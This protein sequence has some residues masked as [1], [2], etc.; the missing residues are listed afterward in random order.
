MS[1]AVRGSKSLRRKSVGF[2][3]RMDNL[4]AR[5]LLATIAVTSLADSGAGS[6]RQAIE[7]AAAN[8]TIDLTGLTGTIT[9]AS[10]IEL[11]KPLTLNG[12]GASR[13]SISGGDAVRIFDQS[14]ASN[15]TVV[16]R[17]MTLRDGRDVQYGGA[18]HV[19]S[20]R[21]HVQAV[22]F[23]SNTASSGGA[24]SNFGHLTV[25]GSQFI[26]NTA[27]ADPNSFT[28]DGTNGGAIY[29]HAA[30]DVQSRGW[31]RTMTLVVRNSLFR[32]NSVDGSA[33]HSPEPTAAGGAI[34]VSAGGATQNGSGGLANL[35]LH[36]NTFL[37]NSS[38]VTGVSA[39]EIR[40]HGGAV[41]L[42]AT[43][44]VQGGGGGTID[45][46][47]RNNTLT[48]NSVITA[49]NAFQNVKEGAG[50][51]FFTSANV[52]GGT[53]GSITGAFHNNLIFDNTGDVDL[54]AYAGLSLT[55]THN[56]VGTN[57][58]PSP[59]ADG[60]TGNMVGDDPLLGE[61]T[62]SNDSVPVMP[63]LVNSPAINA[64][65]ADVAPLLD[66]RRHRR[67]GA[68]DIGA[69]EFNGTNDALTFDTATL[70]SYPAIDAYNTTLS[71][72]VVDDEPVTFRLVDAPSWMSLTDLGNGTA[73]LSGTPSF[74]SPS[75]IS[76]VVEIDDGVV[77]SNRT[78]TVGL[79][80]TVWELSNDGVL[81][82]FGTS[83]DD[84]INVW[85]RQDQLRFVIGGRIRNLPFN[86]VSRV[87]VYGRDG[88][89]RMQ[90]NIRDLP[91]YLA[92]GAGADTL[93]GG[94][95]DDTI[96]GG[97]GK[98]RLLS[99]GGN[100]VL[101]GGLGND[102]FFAR[103]G[104]IDQIDGGSGDDLAEADNNDVVNQ[105]NRLLA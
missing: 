66:Q 81:H 104:L 56:L 49:G 45:L 100:N 34:H 68:P 31:N 20:G 24:I 98:D 99:G 63:L 72:S 5:R 38:S 60:V 3:A 75:D 14:T 47:I 95:G 88:D 62:T 59:V 85:A 103:N 74:D 55:A 93:I 101:R 80:P 90:V 77:T 27:A 52:H 105:A 40:S 91:A 67:T 13:L 23:I 58:G 44:A 43:G 54:R 28:H 2:H 96:F 73:Q 61:L 64:G 94:L 15:E 69:F 71:G 41:N 37:E 19:G 30:G 89:D 42:V 22:H 33:Q 92:G 7:S 65:D 18:L 36:N 102:S 9:L 17:K 26:N 84:T 97:G 82:I 8:D 46:D 32:G 29:A 4:E 12:P 57:G 21:A 50:I 39:I 53:D 86:D 6:L 83:N 1:L 11:N 87:N 16:F 70:P 25:V 76:V 48:A 35:T 51:R 78:Y 10:S 79:E